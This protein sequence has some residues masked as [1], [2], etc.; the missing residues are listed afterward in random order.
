M[1]R[2][3]ALSVLDMDRRQV[4]RLAAYYFFRKGSGSDM[5]KRM[6]DY[7]EKQRLTKDAYWHMKHIPY[8]N[9]RMKK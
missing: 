5:K 4:K 2:N 8:A 9:V 7:Y 3:K 6:A 1:I